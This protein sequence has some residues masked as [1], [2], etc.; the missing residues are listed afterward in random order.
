MRAETGRQATRTRPTFTLPPP[1]FSQMLESGTH[2]RFAANPYLDWRNTAT[3]RIRKGLAML[4][5]NLVSGG[6]WHTQGFCKY[7]FLGLHFLA[8]RTRTREAF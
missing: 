4:T 3:A 7:L 1:S 8:E 2:K 5:K 6:Q